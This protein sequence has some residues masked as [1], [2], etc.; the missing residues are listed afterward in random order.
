RGGHAEI[1][2]G[3]D[4]FDRQPAGLFLLAR[5]RHGTRV[6]KSDQRRI[7]FGG[8]LE[9]FQRSNG[10]IPRALCVTEIC[11][12]ARLEER[13]LTREE[14]EDSWLRLLGIAPRESIARPVNG[15]LEAVS[16]SAG[17]VCQR[18]EAPQHGDRWTRS[19]RLFQTR[20]DM[21]GHL[22]RS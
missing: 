3:G 11:S 17:R 12:T 2:D 20:H 18:G 21:R 6:G 4:G 16:L 14:G 15:T 5:L 10:R 7:S 13:S 22:V 8:L 19:S 9:G 1:T